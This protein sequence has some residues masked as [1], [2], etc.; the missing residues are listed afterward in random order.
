MAGSIELFVDGQSNFRFRL[1]APDGTI[2]AVS[3]AFTDKS[4]A[5]A[6]IEAVRECA[7]MGLIND[8]CPGTGR[9]HGRRQSTHTSIAAQARHDWHKRADSFHTR[10]KT[11]RRA[12]TAPR[13]MGAT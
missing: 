6:G 12:A 3:A 4:A 8:L 9:D 1:K 5:V 13:W 10:A 7:G 2:M 11:V